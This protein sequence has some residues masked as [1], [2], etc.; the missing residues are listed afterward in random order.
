MSCE[1]DSPISVF[2]N[3][4]KIAGFRVSNPEEAGAEVVAFLPKLAALLTTVAR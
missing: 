2:E 1:N 3:A 4:Q